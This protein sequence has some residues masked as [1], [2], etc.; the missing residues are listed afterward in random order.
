MSSNQIFVF[1]FY[2]RMLIGFVLTFAVA[3]NVCSTSLSMHDGVVLKTNGVA[4]SIASLMDGVLTRLKK[5]NEINETEGTGYVDSPEIHVDSL[6]DSELIPKSFPG[7]TP[8]PL[9]ESSSY[10]ADTSLEANSEANTKY[11]LR[12][13]PG[14]I[15]FISPDLLIRSSPVMTEVNLLKAFS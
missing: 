9:V 8:V 10:S 1:Y 12:S 13:N 11:D 4:S 6:E 15:P 7:T 3:S 14:F 5:N 2:P